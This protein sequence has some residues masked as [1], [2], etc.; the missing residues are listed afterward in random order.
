[1]IFGGSVRNQSIL[2]YGQQV[3][4]TVVGDCEIKFKDQ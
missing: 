4:G 2:V 1:M 3:F